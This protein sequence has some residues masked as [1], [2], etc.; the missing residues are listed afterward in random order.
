VVALRT[1][2]IEFSHWLKAH[3]WR[4]SPK[5][6]RYVNLNAARANVHPTTGLG[7]SGAFAAGVFDFYW[8]A[9]PSRN[10]PVRGE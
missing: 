6:W 2:I 4:K 9:A 10:I 8:P 1:S 7:V 5:I 3:G